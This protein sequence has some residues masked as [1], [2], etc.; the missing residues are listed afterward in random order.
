MLSRFV[1]SLGG[2]QIFRV[3]FD[4]QRLDGAEVEFPAFGS[5]LGTVQQERAR[6]LV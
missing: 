2:G 4:P 6:Q 1:H 3:G 5:Q